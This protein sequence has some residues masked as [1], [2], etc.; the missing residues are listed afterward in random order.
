MAELELHNKRRELEST[1]KELEQFAYAASHDMQE[2]LRKIQTYSSFLLQQE[3]GRLSDKGENFLVKINQSTER[4]KGI[5]DALLNYSHFSDMEQVLKPVDLNQVV[6]RVLTDLE[7]LIAQKDAAITSNNL[8]IVAAMDVQMDQLFFNLLHNALKFSRA[9]LSP[10]IDISYK[11]A[12]VEEVRAKGLDERLNYVRISIRDNG[13]GFDSNYSERIFGLF[14]RL[15]GKSMYEG[16]G[17][18]LT[19]CR[20][21]V[22]KHKGAIWVDSDSGKGSEFYILLPLTSG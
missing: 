5:I 21:I 1:N 7:L 2:P 13:I 9:D 6:S 8:P 12:A 15:H 11:R 20:K 22:L 3:K 10:S 4:M 14:Q 16:T 19:L 17:I 18:G